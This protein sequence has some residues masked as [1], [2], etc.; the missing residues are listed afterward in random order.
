MFDARSREREDYSG[1]YFPSSDWIFVDAR[2]NRFNREHV[3]IHEFGHALGLGHNLC[4]DSVM[5][6]SD[7]AD[8]ILYF[9]TTARRM[10][11]EA[12]VETEVMPTITF[13]EIHHT[14]IADLD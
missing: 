5:S 12:A 7:F 8:P 10:V 9:L 4:K 13:Y 14:E 1:A 6:Y 3:I 11:L 2:L